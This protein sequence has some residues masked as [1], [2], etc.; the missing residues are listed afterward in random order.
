M[1]ADS[2]TTEEVD[3]TL[4]AARQ[5]RDVLW[6]AP[7]LDGTKPILRS[8]ASRRIGPGGLSRKS[9]STV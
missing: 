1:W 5:L 2:L 8:A 6:A 3:A 9:S 4:E 7:L